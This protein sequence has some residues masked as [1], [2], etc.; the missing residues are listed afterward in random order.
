MAE[1]RL[2]TNNAVSLLMAPLSSTSTTLTVMLGHGAK[3]P[4]PIASNEF[5]AITLED[6]AAQTHEIIHVT[7]RTGDTFTIQR[8]QENTIARSWSASLGSDTL[9]DHRITAET[10]YYFSDLSYSTPNFP[11]LIDFKTALDY[12]LQNNVVSGGSIV[13]A[14][15]TTVV[16]ELKTTITLL[17]DYKPNTTAVYVG[18]VRQKRGIDFVETAP[19]ELQLQFVLTPTMIAD[20]QNVVV[21]YV[22]A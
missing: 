9:V 6:Q 20:G 11:T 13:D 7:Q 8:G 19:N 15:I 21:D 12:L 5:F 18:G 4:T 10:L 14:D 3:F 1:K 17:T 16:N 22:V 2:F